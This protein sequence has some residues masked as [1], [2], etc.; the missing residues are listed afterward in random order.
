MFSKQTIYERTKVRWAVVILILVNFFDMFSTRKTKNRI[1]TQKQQ[2]NT[3]W[4]EDNRSTFKQKLCP[5][6]IPAHETNGKALFDLARDELGLKIDPEVRGKDKVLNGFYT[7]IGWPPIAYLA[8]R[9]FENGQEAVMENIGNFI[10]AGNQ[11]SVSVGSS[12]IERKPQFG[13]FLYIPVWKCG[14]NS[15]RKN[16]QLTVPQCKQVTFGGRGLGWAKFIGGVQNIPKACA[17]TVVRDPVTHFI[18]GYNEYEFRVSG[19]RRKNIRAGIQDPL[20]FETLDF[21]TEARFEQFVLDFLSGY[22]WD[23][24]FNNFNILHHTFSM[25]GLLTVFHQLFKRK[26]TGY[27]PSLGNIEE[28]FP[29]FLNNTCPGLLPESAYLPWKKEDRYTHASEGDQVGFRAAASRVWGYGNGTSKALCLI[30]AMDYACYDEI[31]VPEICKEVYSRESFVDFLVS[32]D[33]VNPSRAE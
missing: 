1:E 8:E 12:S 6:D 27:L 31:P 32:S 24:S 14:N 21:G 4:F 28:K 29:S 18:S 9:E 7:S 26:L 17:V 5:H 25:T 30:H 22:E 3:W 10:A 23:E 19:K 16:L 20:N 2:S 11:Q 13:S 15:I 33:G